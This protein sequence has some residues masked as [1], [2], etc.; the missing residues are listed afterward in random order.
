[1]YSYWETVRY[2]AVD[3][4]GKLRIPDIVNYL[5]DCCT[6]QSEKLGV[7][8]LHLQEVKKGWLL[9]YW[10]IDFLEEAGL[11]EELEIGTW[12]YDARGI[13]GYRNFLIQTA[14][15]KP[16]VKANSVWV[17][18][19]V[20]S[21]MPV[22]ITPEDVEIYGHEPKLEME[23]TNRKIKLGTDGEKKEAFPIRKYHIDTNG[24][25]NNCWYIQFAME[26]LPDSVYDGKQ[27]I[28]RL[29]A[30]YKKS[31]VYGDKIYPVVYPE[32]NGITISLNDE[33][34]ESYAVIQF[35]Y[36]NQ[37]AKA[38]DLDERF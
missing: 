18:V 17:F 20:E 37:G 31:A 34:E 36:E 19:D 24:H 11:G 8:L 6:M 26:Y 9:K 16:L 23:Y 12:A 25:V 5:Q 3:K 28:T 10:Q 38:S 2:S 27:R 22:R 33:K 14:G 21:G 13:N 15:K 1:M 29:R 32:E 35:L 30:E 7:G 4:N